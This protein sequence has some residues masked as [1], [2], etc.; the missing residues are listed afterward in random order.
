MHA[1]YVCRV[2]VCKALQNT[3]LPMA[4]KDSQSYDTIAPSHTYA[5]SK[6]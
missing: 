4:Q 5:K 1:M 3:T 2:Y 6:P